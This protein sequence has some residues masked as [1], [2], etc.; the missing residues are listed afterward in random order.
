MLLKSLLLHF[1]DVSYLFTLTLFA[2]Q[3]CLFVCS[4]RRG[5]TKLLTNAALK[6]CRKYRNSD[7]SAKE[8][9]RDE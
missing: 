2:P 3:R 1:R 5:A 6:C 8:R 7:R 4:G 9:L